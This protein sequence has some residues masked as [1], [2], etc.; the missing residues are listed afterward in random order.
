MAVVPQLQGPTLAPVGGLSPRQIVIL[1][2]GVGADGQD[3]IG[4]APLYQRVLP[5]ALFLAPN[6]PE[7]YDAAPFGRQWFAL[8]DRS[9]ATR[10][11]GAR[12]ATP[13]LN[14]FIDRALADH[15]CDDRNL[16]LMGFSQGAMMALHVGL[17]RLRPCAGIIAHSGMLLGE[18]A[19]AE[20]I[21]ARPPILLTHGAFDDILPPAA[22]PVAKAALTA[23][24]V[25]VQAHMMPG[26][27]HA[28]DEATI[29][30][31][32]RFLSTLFTAREMD[33]VRQQ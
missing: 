33:G 21:K 19:L 29:R 22:M 2:H 16:V 18:G 24:D 28:I 26:L 10:L 17:R 23:A 6:A 12:S 20:E 13:I 8:G 30:L 32:L 14:T 25:P 4:L 9:P 5:D 7:A 1:L 3:L 27:G 15:H 31:D 11:A